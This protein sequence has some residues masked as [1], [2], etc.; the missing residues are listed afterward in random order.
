MDFAKLL[1]ENYS[2]PTCLKIADH[3]VLNPSEMKDFLKLFNAGNPVL[4]Q[5]AAW[6]IR[7]IGDACPELI[8]KHAVFLISLLQKPMHP[9]VNRNVLGVFQTAAIPP[10]QMGLLTDLCFA[11]IK[12]TKQPVAIRTFSMSVLYNICQS[13]PELKNELNLI[14]EDMMFSFLI[15]L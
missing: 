5:R 2:K 14:I 4:C 9:A 1:Y 8:T 15:N 6:V 13:E 11:F 10:S 3:I 12:D 7:F